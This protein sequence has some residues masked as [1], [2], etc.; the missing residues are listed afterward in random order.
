[1]PAFSQMSDRP[2]LPRFA[3]ECDIQRC[4]VPSVSTPVAQSN[5]VSRSVTDAMTAAGPARSWLPGE[6][7]DARA[8]PQASADTT[9]ASV[10]VLPIMRLSVLHTHG[11][12]LHV[13]GKSRNVQLYS[14][15]RY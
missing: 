5:L 11:S 4:F 15:C 7:P 9:I 13:R 12:S 10:I 1:M 2:S 8:E 14:G 6:Q 3:I